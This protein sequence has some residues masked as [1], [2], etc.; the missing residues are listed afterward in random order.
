MRAEDL[1]LGV[2]FDGDADRA[3]F[4][5][6]QLRPLP[7]STVTAIVAG[8]FLARDPGSTIVHNLICS[9]AVPETVTAPA[10][11]RSGPGSGIRS[12]RRS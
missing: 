5:D 7:G 8:W 2:A 6:D 3:F 11:R 1:D 9:K 10:G 12:S 4:I